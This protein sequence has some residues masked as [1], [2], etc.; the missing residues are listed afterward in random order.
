MKLSY[1]ELLGQ[2]H[3]ICFSLAASEELVK[4]F[5]S[6]EH[7]A[8]ALDGNDLAQTAQAVDKTFQI[9]LKA[10]RIYASAIGE[11]L[12]PELPCRP[13]D[14]IDVRDKEPIASIFESVRSDAK[15]TVETESKNGEAAS[16]Q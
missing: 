3:P 2:K 6:M 16:D 15:R 10:G 1:V 13:A 9:L 14:V 12:P 4:E 11:E 8:D 5:G 7:F